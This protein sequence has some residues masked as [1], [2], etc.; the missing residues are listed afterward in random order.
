M[1][2]FCSAVLRPA[3]TTAGGSGGLKTKPIREGGYAQQLLRVG[4]KN[5]V[6][7]PDN[8]AAGRQYAETIAR[9]G[10]G[11]GLAVK[12]IEVPGLPPGGDVVDYLNAGHTKAELFAALEAASR[13]E[14]SSDDV[15]ATDDG[16][17][18]TTLGDLLNEPVKEERFL[19]E[20]RIPCGQVVALVSKPKVGKSTS[21][22]GLALEVS[23]GGTWLGFSCLQAP[24]WYL[25]LE[26]KRSEVSRHFRRVGATGA[27]PVRFLFDQPGKDIIGQLQR[28]AELEHPGLIIVDTLQRLI[29]ARD[30]NDYAEVTT[31]LTPLLTLARQTEAA[32][33]LVH[34][35]GKGKGR[36]AIDTILGSTAIA[37][38]VDN[39]LMM[40]RTD[41]H[42]VLSSMQRTGPDLEEVVV[43]LDEDTGHVD[44]GRTR[45]E[46][47]LIYVK[48]AMLNALQAAGA[49]L[50]S[51]EWC[52]A[53]EA[54]KQLK[55]K[56]R[57]ALV[58]EQKVT[59]TGAGKPNNPYLY[60]MSGSQVPAYSGEPPER[61]T[62]TPDRA[63]E[64]GGLSS[65]QSPGIIEKNW[66]PHT[67]PKNGGLLPRADGE[68]GIVTPPADGK[69]LPLSATSEPDF[70]EF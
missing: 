12:V 23:R 40:S 41:R 62:K 28:L 51:D 66:E 39:I 59:R 18:L 22:R 58:D 7:L 67:G 35:A 11:A 48:T 60:E 26:D 19:V 4:V 10:H 56:A 57:R 38:S 36:E 31:K 37:G 42:R 25:A 64:N 8:D 61:D 30:L 21:A 20:D 33:L 29:K 45:E 32:V 63:N 5:L 2:Y 3:T 1:V 50:T 52:E 69:T 68:P 49:A 70:E 6:V 54:R 65:S 55:L 53:V 15:P 27:E 46:A 17:V 13:Y 14:P 43:T 44:V 34:H 47:D 9:A 16:L 24:V